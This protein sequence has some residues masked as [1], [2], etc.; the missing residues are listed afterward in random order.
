MDCIFCKIAS[1]EMSSSKVYENDSV[2]AFDDIRPL[3][4]V[5][6]L[7]IPKKHIE[8]AAALTLQDADIMA[9]MLNAA[10]EAASIKGIKESGFRIITNSGADSG[11]EVYHLHLH[12]LGGKQLG[13]LLTH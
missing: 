7:I 11:Q 12:L 3:A 5:H 9:A 4:P 10:I 1:G 13:P 2:L 6:V 8:N